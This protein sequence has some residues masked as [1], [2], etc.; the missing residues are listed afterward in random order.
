MQLDKQETL[1]YVYKREFKKLTPRIP[2][3]VVVPLLNVDKQSIAKFFP[4]EED[5]KQIDSIYALLNDPEHA[6]VVQSCSG[7][8]KLF[9]K[10]ILAKDLSEDS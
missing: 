9:D 10:D 3:D 4:R 6:E 8:F 5:K 7:E 2:S 1:T